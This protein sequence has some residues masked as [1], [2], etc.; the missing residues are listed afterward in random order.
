MSRRRWRGAVLAVVMAAAA[1]TGEGSG[2]P[3]P[4]DRASTTA[5]NHPLPAPV[6]VRQQPDN[7]TLADPKFDPLPGARAEFGRLGG[8]VFQIEM[9]DRWNGRLVLWMHGFEEFRSEAS[10]GAP[11]IRAYLIAEGYAW[12]S[13]SFSG[14]GWIP[15]RAADETAALWDH[16][17]AMH[18]RPQRTYAIGESMG[19]AAGNIAAERYPNRFDGVMALCG[20]AGATSGLQNPVNVFIAGA[21]V[22]GVTQADYDAA[23]DVGALIRDRIRPALRHP[24]SRDRFERIMVDLSGG[25]RPFDREGIRA[26]EDTDWQR[27]QLALSTGV[28]PHHDAPYHLGPTSEVNEDE[29]NRAAIRL[30]TNDDLL[31]AYVAGNEATGRLRVPLLTMHTTGDGQVP[32]DEARILQRRVD[33]AGQHDRLVQRVV[34]DPGH[35]GFTNTELVAGFEALVGWAEHHTK[36][37]GHD[38]LTA[39]LSA[40]R[41][42]FELQ[43]RPGTP[44]AGTVTGAGDRVVVRGTATVDGVPLEAR[45]FG[46][47]VVHDGLM[48]HCQ[49]ALSAVTGGAFDVTVLAD[50]ETSGCGARGS[51]IV[52]W[53]YVGGTQLTQLHSISALPW[54]GN[55][56]TITADVTFS[57]A[58][59]LGAS[60]PVT[61]FVGEV[62]DATGHYAR[63]GTRIEAFV[64]DVRCGV[65]AIR[66][67]GGFSGYTLVTAGP[68]AVPACTAG[69]TILFRIDGRRALQ[70][71]TNDIGL[72]R[73]PFDL[74]VA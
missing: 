11:D 53:T 30:R 14:T 35:C 34:R 39:D 21:F 50:S 64:G 28:V 58:T 13:S 4:P 20:S 9:P 52:F 73:S 7:V 46:A 17:T 60:T 18:G 31:R 42:A 43:P 56:M 66:R 36:P 62:L 10:V 24:Q 40:L 48:A 22:A 37:K 5:S 70:T 41:P 74:T 15:G 29:F 59:P 71:A 68:D 57:T 63:P 27:A 38:V 61:S 54:P 65:T 55:G 2:R 45:F 69:A 49:L 44:E 32:I 16:F 51:V 6:D 3:A 33:A 67:T 26:E 72:Q 47:E 8:T 23:T 1:C 25:P 19:G 12:G